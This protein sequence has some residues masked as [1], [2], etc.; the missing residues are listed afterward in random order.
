M[1][2]VILLIQWSCL[3]TF[4]EANEHFGIRKSF[5]VLINVLELSVSR[6]SEAN[7][8]SRRNVYVIP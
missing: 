5:I 3:A 6:F 2:H 7:A 4:N 1:L 8:P